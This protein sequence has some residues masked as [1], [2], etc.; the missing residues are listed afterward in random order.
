MAWEFKQFQEKFKAVYAN[1]IDQMTLTIID[2]ERSQQTFKQLTGSTA[3]FEEL[4][5]SRNS[6]AKKRQLGID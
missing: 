5:R 1:E 3:D 6:P 2:T 4:L